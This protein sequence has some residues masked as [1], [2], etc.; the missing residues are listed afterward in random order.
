MK[1]KLQSVTQGS[2]DVMQNG[3]FLG[4]VSHSASA[5]MWWAYDRHGKRISTWPNPKR[6]DA[7]KEVARHAGAL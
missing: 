4:H 7:V 1:V 3:H 6:S 5:R 2:A